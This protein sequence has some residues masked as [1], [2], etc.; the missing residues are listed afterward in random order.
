MSA[1]K[2]KR[3]REMLGKRKAELGVSYERKPLLNGEE[4]SKDAEQTDPMK[5]LIVDEGA[6]D[7]E[8]VKSRTPKIQIELI[9]LEQEEQRD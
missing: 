2:K 8:K 1:K 6:M 5:A 3:L 4:P 7:T 9:D